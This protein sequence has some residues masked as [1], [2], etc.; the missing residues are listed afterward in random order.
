MLLIFLQTV[1][2]FALSRKI[3]NVYS[4]LARKYA[5]VT[6]KNFRQYEKLEYKKNKLKLD[7]DFLNNRK[8]LG[9]YP[10]FFIFKLPNIL[11]KDT[12]SIRKRFLLSAINKRNKEL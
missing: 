11:N 5:N 12:S 4:N 10:K 6:F 9:V 7:T 1:L 8:E 2:S 3:I